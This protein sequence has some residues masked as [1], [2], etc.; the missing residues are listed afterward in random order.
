MSVLIIKN[1][2][3]QTS[4]EHSK[5]LLGNQEY[6]LDLVGDYQKKKINSVVFSI[7]KAITSQRNFNDYSTLEIK[8]ENNKL[9]VKIDGTPSITLDNPKIKDAFEK[10]VFHTKKYLENIS[11]R[12]KE[13]EQIS[14]ESSEIIS[15]LQNEVTKVRKKYFKKNEKNDIEWL[16]LASWGVS[17]S[18]AY[19]KVCSFFDLKST[20]LLNIPVQGIG[21]LVG[22]ITSVYGLKEGY[23][24]KRD[25]SKVNDGEGIFE[26]RAKMTRHA[27]SIMAVFFAAVGDLFYALKSNTLR[28]T[29]ST[30]LGLGMTSISYAIFAIVTLG[31]TLKYYHSYKIASN[32]DE[33]LNSYLKNDVLSEQNKSLG[34]LKFLRESITLSKE[35]IIE[36]YKR[37]KEKNP[38]LEN[39]EIINL[40][41][42]ETRKRQMVKLYR[43][44]RRLSLSDYQ[45]KV[46]FDNLDALSLKPYFKE[47]REKLSKIITIIKELNQI[48]IAE[49]KWYAISA[50]FSV[51]QLAA[52]ACLAMHHLPL[53]LGFLSTTSF[54]YISAIYFYKKHVTDRKKEEKIKELKEYIFTDKTF[55]EESKD[56]ELK[57][58]VKKEFLGKHFVRPPK[59][60]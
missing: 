53:L 16:F 56:D 35:E 20:P 54:V 2:N 27:F 22:Y 30:S 60:A 3:I 29:I 47:S 59:V 1:S 40:A 23:E 34:A 15:H 49:S 6:S 4:K 5:L 13:V 46:I 52:I 37:I 24:L 31:S 33:R 39:L 19:Y 28:P 17:I 7:L 44:S 42:K 18:D 43:L 36:I 9:Q 50:L 11:F 41:E 8:V 32:F 55:D 45:A 14:S 38:D 21:D 48:T 25:S 26:G 12:N 57:K 10:A 58:R 51:L